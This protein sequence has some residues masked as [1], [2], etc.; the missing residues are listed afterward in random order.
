MSKILSETLNIPY[1]EEQARISFEVLNMQDLDVARL[2]NDKF[3]NFQQD[4]LRR[5]INEEYRHKDNFLSD[6]TTLCN[7]AYYEANTTDSPRIKRG[8]KDIA[9]GNFLHG[10]DLVI[11]VPIIFGLVLDGVRNKSE[12]YRLEIDYIIQ[13]YLYLNDNVY[14]LKSE[15]IEN[16]VKELTEVIN[17]WKIK[18]T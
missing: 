14:E 17:K 16:R 12:D 11:Y 1:I 8:Y 10:Y 15:G 18:L 5:Q 3:S 4:V 7:Y 6:R 13:N 9:L 2:D